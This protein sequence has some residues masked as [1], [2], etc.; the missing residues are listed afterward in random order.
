MKIGWIDFSN[1][2]RKKSL[3]VIR[4]LDEE[5]AI[6]ELGI[7][8]VR[9]AFADK[10]FPAT[11]TLMTR[12]KYFFLIPYAFRDA[13]ADRSL[14]N[15]KIIIQK[16]EEEIEKDCALVLKNKFPNEDGIIGKRNLPS[17]WVTRKPSSIYWSSL[18]Q[19]GIFTYPELS[20][21]GY[22]KRALYYRQ[23]TK[24]TTKNKI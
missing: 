3:N 18:K 9:D 11:S 12:A 8:R 6:D 19:T 5:G 2:D 10:F 21:E 1:N 16:V 20:I 4:L 15:S 23:N 14:T 24:S 17:G 7:G 22:V 13:L